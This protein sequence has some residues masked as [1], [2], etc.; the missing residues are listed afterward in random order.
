MEILIETPRTFSFKRTILSHGWCVLA[1]F[2]FDKET[3]TLSR[4]LDAG[5]AQPVTVSI[6]GSAGGLKVS[7]SRK[8]GKDAAGRVKRDV[9]HI[10][11]LDDDLSEFYELVA[12]EGDFAWVASEGA[13][14]LLRAPTVFEDLVKMICT[15][16]CSWGLTTRMVT[17]LVESLG[18]ESANGRRAFPTAEAM[19]AR[20][21]RFYRDR[22]RAGYRAPYLRELA[23]RV[24]S[25]ELDVEQWLTS[26][27]ETALLKK[28]MKKVKG[29]GDYAAEN[30]LKLV[31][32]YDGLALDSW[33]RPTFSRLRNNGRAASDRKIERYYSRFDRW[34]GLALWCDLTRA[35]LDEQQVVNW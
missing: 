18:A 20:P 13:G 19:A 32:R 27:L 31:G 21:E 1:P 28:E 3:W 6:T 35:W 5:D 33:V 30:L 23:K 4:V 26:P 2:S 17:G 11:R 12:R 14:R 9:R 29:V 16:N 34:R 25:R 8:L 22:I 10:F 24:A 15:T 7:T